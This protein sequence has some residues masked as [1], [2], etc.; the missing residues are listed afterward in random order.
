MSKALTVVERPFREQ[1]VSLLLGRGAHVDTFAAIEGVPERLRGEPIQGSSHTI[2]QLLE[3]MRL[4]QA[5]ILDYMTNPGYVEPVWPGDYWPDKA[6]PPS[7][8]AWT[9]SVGGLRE[10]LEKVTQIA[11]DPKGDLLAQIPHGE[12]GHTPLREILILSDHNAYHTGQIV[13]LRKLAGAWK[14]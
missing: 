6:V 4:T 5:D 9:R 12:R 2:W 14:A 13:L 8:E 3:H 10:D 1:L 7:N 11:L